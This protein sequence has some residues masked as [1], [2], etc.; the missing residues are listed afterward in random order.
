M[1]VGVYMDYT[2]KRGVQAE[3]TKLGW[4]DWKRCTGSIGEKKSSY[5]HHEPDV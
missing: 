1:E 3:D 2:A 4:K 5:L